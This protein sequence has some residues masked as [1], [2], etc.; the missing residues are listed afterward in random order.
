MSNVDLLN[1]SS[2]PLCLLHV[3]QLIITQSI[4]FVAARLNA[5]HVQLVPKVMREETQCVNNMSTL[6]FTNIDLNH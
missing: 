6:L 2:A 5:L 1:H 3:V 4:P